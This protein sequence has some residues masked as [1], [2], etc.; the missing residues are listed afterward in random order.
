M[1]DSKSNMSFYHEI[2]LSVA[3]P[4]IIVCSEGDVIE[5]FNGEGV[6]VFETPGHHP[7]CLSFL[8]N[9]YLFT[10][11]SYIPGVKIVTNLPKG[12]K[13]MARQ[14][15]DRLLQLIPISS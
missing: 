10:G 7:S 6:S 14:S 12:D 3:G 4:F 1:A 2:P 9:N 5:L 15:L 8:V 11:D 13:T